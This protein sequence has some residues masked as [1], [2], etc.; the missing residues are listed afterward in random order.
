[1]A[2]PPFQSLRRAVAARRHTAAVLFHTERV[3]EPL[4]QEHVIGLPDAISTIP[5]HGEL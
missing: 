3:E 4:L 2:C 1:M 5:R